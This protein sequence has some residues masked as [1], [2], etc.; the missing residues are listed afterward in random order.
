MSTTA[1]PSSPVHGTCDQRFAAVRDAF[2]RNFAERDEL[3]AAV[4]VMVDGEPVVDLWGGVADPATGRAW[5]QD[6]MNV[7]M[8]CSKGVVATCVHLLIDRG[9]LDVDRP[10]AHYWPEFAAHGKRD[11]PVHLAL[12]HQSGVAHV[13]PVVPVGALSDLDLM[14]RLTADTPPYWEP[15]TRTGYHGLSIGWIEGELIRRITGLTPGQFLRREISEPLGIDVWLGLPE[16][17]EDRVATTV[18]FDLAAEAGVSPRM[19]EALTHP[20][21][22]EH[23]LLR[24][25]LS[26]GPLRSAAARAAVRKGE[27]RS[28][29]A[30]L[31]AGFVRNLLDPRSATFAFLT[32][33]GDYL[34]NVNTREAHA[35]EIPAAGAIASARGLAGLYAPLALDGAHR[36]VRLVA[37]GAIAGMRI[38]RAATAMDAVIGTPTTYTLGFSGSWP[39]D[40]P[41]S[42]VMIGEDAFGTPGAG[43]QLGFADPAYRLSFAYVMNRHG[44]GTGLNER[45]QSLVDAVYRSLGSPGRAH[46]SWLRP[47]G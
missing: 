11:I 19:W 6:T 4:C 23:A 25:L 36:G 47:A 41:G 30:G 29:G 32:N 26:V 9:E 5:E 40:R 45:G 43:G 28:P 12:S 14:T 38:P 22:R 1:T 3:G 20:A 35:G 2:T 42:G 24:G 33:T 17:H 44:A 34:A 39:S 7:I 16:E 46:G 31:P 13:K 21:S 10:I 8:S 37:P 15:G 18:M 27:R